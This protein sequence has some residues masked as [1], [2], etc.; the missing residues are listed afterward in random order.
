MQH[1]PW[2]FTQLSIHIVFLTGSAITYVPR[3]GT[4]EKPINFLCGRKP[5]CSEKTHNIWQSIHVCSLRSLTW[6][7]SRTEKDLRER[8]VRKR[9]QLAP[10]L[11]SRASG[12]LNSNTQDPCILY[13]S[14]DCRC[15]IR[16]NWPSKTSMCLVT[17]CCG[18]PD[19]KSYGKTPAQTLPTNLT[20]TFDER[21]PLKQ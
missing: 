18:Y 2:Y 1:G 5:K 9:R 11:S 15:K 19:E 3:L 4:L 10:L 16:V 17:W 8:P 20:K 6:E 12:T 14:R 7:Q 13:S 21:R